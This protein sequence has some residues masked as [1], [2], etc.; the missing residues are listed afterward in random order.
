MVHYN[1][2]KTTVYLDE[3]ELAR[4]KAL[5][6]EQHV[7]PAALIRKAISFLIDAEYAPLPQGTGEYHSGEA[8]G[9]RK[10]KAILAR[11]TRRGR[12]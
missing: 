3:A 5:A 2:Q 1:M 6:A 7:K 9:S 4:L 10:R 8:Q 11:A 12:W